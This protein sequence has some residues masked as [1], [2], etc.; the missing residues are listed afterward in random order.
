MIPELTP[1]QIEGIAS[2]EKI[3]EERCKKILE[4]YEKLKPKPKTKTT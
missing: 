3:R 1:K 2:H 4:K